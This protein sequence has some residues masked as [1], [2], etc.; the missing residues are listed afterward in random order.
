MAFTCRTEDHHEKILDRLCILLG[1]KAKNKAVLRIVEEYENIVQDRDKYQHRMKQLEKELS[2]V[3]QAVK[4]KF[5]ADE[6]LL[7]I[8]T[9]T[10][11][12]NDDVF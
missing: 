9:K 3:K 6:K 7:Q 11:E 1:I 10:N 4:S 12:K 2:A 8:I 5:E